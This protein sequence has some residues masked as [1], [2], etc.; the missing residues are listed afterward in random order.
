VQPLAEDSEDSFISILSLLADV[1]LVTHVFGPLDIQASS[2]YDSASQFPECQTQVPF[3]PGHEIQ[4]LR[5]KMSSSLV[6]W[7]NS[8]IESTTN[9]VL[10]LYYFCRLYSLVPSLQS[11]FALSGYAKPSTSIPDGEREKARASAALSSYRNAM[12][13]VW[14]ILGISELMEPKELPI[15]A[16][17]SVF[18]AGL[19]IWACKEFARPDDVDSWSARSLNPFQEELARMNFSGAKEMSVI[20]AKLG[21]KGSR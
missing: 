12:S 15:W 19:V 5:Q 7:K 16:P 2:I 10:L 1:H 14:Q 8:H 4:E 6:E 20:L 11:L 9:D 18:S 17:L 3:T 13:T 21:R